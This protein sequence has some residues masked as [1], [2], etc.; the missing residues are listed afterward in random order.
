M[1][2]ASFISSKNLLLFITMLGLLVMSLNKMTVAKKDNNCFAPSY[3]IAI[4]IGHYVASPGAISATGITEFSYNKDLA[5]LLVESLHKANFT[6][7][8]LIGESGEPLPLSRRIELIA[9]LNANLVISLHHDSVQPIYLK[10]WTV[11]GSNHKYSDLFHGFSI[12][13]SSRNIKAEDSI[14]FARMLGRSLMNHGLTPSLHHGERIAG[15]NRKLLD[16]QLGLYQF[17]NLEILRGVPIAAVLLESG[18][19]VNRSEEQNIRFGSYHRDVADSIVDAVDK[20][21]SYNN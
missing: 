11:N 13:V 1:M 6:N 2:Y 15:E 14:K 8:S 5:K 17:D 12:F 16:A 19:I 7:I 18:V 3:R 9:N 20:F 4:D 21:C 10:D